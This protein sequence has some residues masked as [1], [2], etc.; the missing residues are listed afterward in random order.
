MICIIMMI[1]TLIMLAHIHLSCME[2]PLKQSL[3]RMI[4]VSPCFSMLL[5]KMS[6]PHWRLQLHTFGSIIT[7]V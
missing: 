1:L 4:P 3:M 5:F 7:L 2:M 6:I